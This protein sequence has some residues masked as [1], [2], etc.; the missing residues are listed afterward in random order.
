MKIFVLTDESYSFNS[1]TISSV[2]YHDSQIIFI[3][4]N[5][6]I[7]DFISITLF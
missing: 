1:L 4:K 3:L 2:I 6:Q 5:E 7:K